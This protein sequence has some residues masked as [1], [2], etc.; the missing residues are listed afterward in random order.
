[1]EKKNKYIAA[2]LAFFAGNFG[3]HRFY[4]NQPLWGVLYLMTCGLFGIGAIIDAI[5]FLTMSEKQFDLRY[6]SNDDYISGSPDK[7]KQNIAARLKRARDIQPLLVAQQLKD[8]EQMYEKG[9]IN[10][11]EFEYLKQKLLSGM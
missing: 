11:E 8:L 9:T 6:N 4:L 3:A 10:F 1:M 5:V 2:A 7:Y